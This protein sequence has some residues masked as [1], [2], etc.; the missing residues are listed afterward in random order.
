MR[1]NAKI[2]K[3][4]GVV[5]KIA[6]I[7]AFVC[8]AVY[9][10]S[11]LF[12]LGWAFLQSLKTNSE[13]WENMI[14]LPKKWLLSNYIKAFGVLEY[15]KTTFAGMFINSFW[16]AAGSTLLSVLSHCVTGYVFAK[17]KFKGREAAFSF[18]LFTL[19]IPIVGSLPSLYKVIYYLNLNDSPLFLVTAL[20]GFGGNF[21]ITYA[22][23]KNI[24]WAY[25]EAAFIDGA[26]HW[27]VFFRIYLPLAAGPV[28]ALSILGF[29]GQW[30]NYETPML[31]LDKNYPTL[32]SGLYNFKIQM[33]FKSNEPL[34]TAGVLVSTLPVF[35]LV[36]AF[37]NQIMKNMTI[38]GI[39]G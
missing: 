8:F 29:I 19:T 32:A 39:K 23:F 15:N 10:F 1:E 9:S 20:G 5:A 14:A 30:N 35:I 18:V 26:G 36:A 31:F 34:Y 4:A 11:M 7:I 21:L 28:A 13:F 24:D 12:T 6:F 16:F 25:A 37:G 17:Y 38:G 22:Y 2:L 33:R 27:Y 3:P